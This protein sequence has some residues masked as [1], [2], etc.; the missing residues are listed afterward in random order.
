MKVG[1]FYR[2]L[3]I[4]HD[5]DD[6]K[7]TTTVNPQSTKLRWERKEYNSTHKAPPEKWYEK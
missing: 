1:T 4:E 6:E 7:H 5:V 2:I 3:M